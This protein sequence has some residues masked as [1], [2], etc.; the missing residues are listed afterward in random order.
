[1]QNWPQAKQ[2]M[3]TY[4]RFVQSS[5]TPSSNFLS[6]KVGSR[7][8]LW[9]KTMKEDILPFSLAAVVNLM[10]SILS[11]MSWMWGADKRGE[12]AIGDSANPFNSWMAR[13][14]KNIK[15][16][17][18]DFPRNWLLIVFRWSFSESICHDRDSCSDMVMPSEL[19]YYQRLFKVV[20][21][22]SWQDSSSASSTNHRDTAWFDLY[23]NTS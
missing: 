10:V 21:C 8:D 18:G 5:F 15:D 11:P 19:S 9:W 16:L 20:Y 14:S 12:V 17:N 2:W 6:L 3:E 4:F 13:I 7:H 1:M 22:S 23:P